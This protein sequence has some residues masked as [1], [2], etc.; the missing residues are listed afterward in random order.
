MRLSM[1]RGCDTPRQFAWLACRS[2]ARI[3]A[4]TKWV[5]DYAKRH[6]KE[7]VF[8]SR[9]YYRD[10]APKGSIPGVLASDIEF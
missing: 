5:I 3:P 1:R 7:N 2:P 6:G 10:A 4:N 9:H 8:L